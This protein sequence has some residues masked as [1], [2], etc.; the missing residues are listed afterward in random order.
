MSEPFQVQLNDLRHLRHIPHSVP[1][2][3]QSE[4]VYPFANYTI[5]EDG[6]ER[7]E[8]ESAEGV[9]N[10]DLEIHFG[11]RI[12]LEGTLERLMISWAES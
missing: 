10:C 5:D 1:L 2:P 4:I 7:I 12:I 9:V 8:S 6:L 3:L 11:D